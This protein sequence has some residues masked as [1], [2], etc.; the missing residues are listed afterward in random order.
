MLLPIFRKKSEL[1]AALAPPSSLAPPLPATRVSSLELA[2]VY[3][4]GNVGG[5]KH[6]GADNRMCVEHAQH[7]NM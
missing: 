3:T 4:G 5:L 2:A 6:G 1:N 7:T